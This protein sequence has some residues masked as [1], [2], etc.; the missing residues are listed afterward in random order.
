MKI[1]GKK[2][3]SIV[4]VTLCAAMLAGVTGF[5]AAATDSGIGT[6]AAALQ[7]SLSNGS[8]LNADKDETVY[9]F[10]GADGAANDVIVTEWLKNKDDAATIDDYSELT[11]IS[12]TSGDE[13]FTAAGG[14]AYVWHAD[15]NEVHYSGKT[16]KPLPVAVS[17]SYYLDGTRMDPADM[18]GRS[19][20]VKICFDYTN[21]EKTTAVIDGREAEIY[22]PFLMVSG[23]ILDS[24]TFSNVSVTNGTVE[25]DGSRNIVVGYGLPGMTESLG[26][27]SDDINIS[28][29]VTIEADTTD[30]ALSNTVTVAMAGLF[31]N[32][33]FD[34]DGKLS[35]IS[36]GMDDLDNAAAEL[37]DGTNTLYDGISEL[38][39]NCGSLQSGIDSLES[40]T[41]ALQSGAQSV[42]DGAASLSGGLSSLAANGSTLVEGAQQMVDAM[43][44]TATASLRAQLVSSG[45]MTKEQADT[46][47][48]TLSNYA[49]VF[50][51]LTG[52]AKA[53]AESQLRG[54]LAAAGLSSDQ[55]SLALSLAFDLMGSDDSLTV[56]SAVTKAATMLGE[57]AE[58]QTACSVINDEWLANAQVQSY[59]AE[60]AAAAGTDT[61][62]A[63]QIAAVSMSLS[64]SAPS[65]QI[66]TAAAMLKD[67]AAVASETAD[68]AKIDSLC[69]TAA[70]GASA[71]YSALNEVKSDLDSVAAFY[72]GLQTYTGGVSSAYEGSQQL[73]G[74][75]SSLKDGVDAMAAGVSTL[76]EGSSRFVS[77][78]AQLKDGAAAL[79]SGMQQFYSD[80]ITKLIGNFK[81]DYGTLYSRL[82][83][84]VDA[85]SSYRSFG[86]I[87][88]GMTGQTKFIFRTEAVG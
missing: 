75:A 16:T 44:G 17:V 3:T 81:G 77:G 9:V 84:I 15:G 54:S 40:G 7:E 33:A 63:A 58:V 88:D 85:G 87:S 13:T 80:G 76:D 30:F 39:S 2:I 24:G 60:I 29:S 48:L 57:A 50:A 67:A 4:S 36:D 70:M 86:G 78:V 64:P 62:T 49:D 56:S 1:S 37:L 23:V 51:Q 79:Q 10:A 27:T 32:I 6:G 35:A 59:I 71:Q 8:T 47:T 66:Q 83:A 31:G 41:Q 11:D 12:N 65:G 5:R 34:K 55:Q 25:N 43:F 22:I 46:V 68:T 72:Y 26:V 74:G 73:S 42:S 20:H 28:D 45:A 14:N 18:A 38:Y 82:Q 61:G 21:N 52:A 19:G 69:V 53:E